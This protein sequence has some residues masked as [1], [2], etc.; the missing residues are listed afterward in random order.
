M[1]I[2]DQIALVTGGAS[3]MGRATAAHLSALGA[4]V[5]LIDI[6]LEINEIAADIGAGARGYTADVADE[7]GMTA[8]LDAIERDFGG[9]PRIVVNCAGICPAARTVGRDGPHPLDLFEKTLR[10]NLVGS[11]NVLRLT[12]AR[13]A[14]APALNEDGECGVVINTASVAAFEGQIG[15]AAYA[16]SKGG[17]VGMTLPIAREFA[18][19]GI[20]IVTIAPGIMETPMLAGMSEEVRDS[21]TATMLFPKRLGKADEFAKLAAHICENIMING[22]TIR[23][24]GALRLAPR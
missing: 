14:E 5:A 24:D 19:L 23:L 12:A 1:H 18:K 2:H 7:A 13:M 17:I 4:K 16:A 3:G 11:F 22:E 8:A 6:A 20:R 9:T 15:Q 21:L 10:V